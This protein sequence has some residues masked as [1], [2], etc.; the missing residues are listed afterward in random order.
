MWRLELIA[1]LYPIIKVS[2]LKH[3]IIG[4]MMPKASIALPTEGWA[5]LSG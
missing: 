3:A 5:S 1:L 4:M 2:I